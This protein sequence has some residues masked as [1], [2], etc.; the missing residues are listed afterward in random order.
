M[1]INSFPAEYAAFSN[2]LKRV[3]VYQKKFNLEDSSLGRTWNSLTVFFH[4]VILAIY[5]PEHKYT[6]QERLSFLH[7]VLLSDKEWIRRFF[8][9]QYKAD[10][11]GKFLLCR[12][13]A[14]AL[15]GGCVSCQV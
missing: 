8:L 2:F 11:L 1:R 7:Q 5:K 4:K 3:Y 9:P 10:V 14:S 15:M 13:G 6:R 12:V